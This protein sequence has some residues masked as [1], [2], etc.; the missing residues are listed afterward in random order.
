MTAVRKA[1]SLAPN[2]FADGSGA[3]SGPDNRI[4][5]DGRLAMEEG[6]PS[7]P[8]K[9]ILGSP[10]GQVN[11]THLRKQAERKNLAGHDQ[12]PRKCGGRDRILMSRFMRKRE[13]LC[14]CNNLHQRQQNPPETRV[15]S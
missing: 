9:K 10:V 4:P 14:V 3:K 8:L 15:R 6:T 11:A 12:E 5:D 2:R 7:L 1:F 13:N